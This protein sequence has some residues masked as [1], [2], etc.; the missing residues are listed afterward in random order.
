MNMQYLSYIVTATATVAY[1]EK[2]NIYEN[3]L[4]LNKLLNK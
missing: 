3:K 1:D 4:N 2:N